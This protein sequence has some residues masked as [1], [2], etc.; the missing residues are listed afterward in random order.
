MAEYMVIKDNIIQAVYCGEAESSKNIIMLPEN[1]EI[2]VGEDIAFYNDNYTRKSD[3]ELMTLGLMDIPNGYKIE[4]NNLVE[5]TSDERI[6]AGL[7]TLPRFF[8]IVENCLVEMEEYEKLEIMTK[9]EKENYH[10]D[11]RD[12]LINKEIW[13]IQRHEHEKLLGISTTLN[14]DEFLLLLKYI[15]E[16]RDITSQEY[17]PDFVEY[18][19]LL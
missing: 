18:P 11:K 15:Q 3:V 13:K 5:M 16:L 1:H 17:F 4:N 8:K 6:I 7:D 2:R 10:R 12:S 19:V 14:D 9:E